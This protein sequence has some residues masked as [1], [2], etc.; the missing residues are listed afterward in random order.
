MELTTP[1]KY[2]QRDISVFQSLAEIPYITFPTRLERMLLVVCISGHI[3][4]YIDMESRTVGPND[5]LVLRPGHMITDCVTDEN[6]SGFFITATQEKINQLLPSLRYVVPYSLF[7]YDNPIINITDEELESLKLIYNMLSK[8]LSS[9][10]RPYHNMA[11]GAM[12]EVLFFNTLGIYASRLKTSVHKSRKEDLLIKF[13][14]ILEDNFMTERSVTFY[15]DK[16]FVTPKHLSAVLKEISEKTAGEW[17]DLRVI[18]EAKLLLRSTGLNIQE[19]STKLNF[20][21]QSFFGKYF[22]HLTGMSPR[23]Y[24]AKLSEA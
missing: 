6:F 13:I 8:Q 4:A 2:Q 11:L 19:I 15:A 1:L 12:C 17:I 23:D 14:Q 22:K 9:T 21:N 5:I 7:F 16:L 3:S 10:P 18:L 20:A 24:R